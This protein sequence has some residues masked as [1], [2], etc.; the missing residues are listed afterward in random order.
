MTMKTP[1]QTKVELLTSRIALLRTDG[2]NFM[3]YSTG[4]MAQFD[5]EADALERELNTLLEAEAVRYCLTRI[6]SATDWQ[7]LHEALANH[8]T[9]GPWLLEMGDAGLGE[10]QRLIRLAED[11]ADERGIEI[12]Y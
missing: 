3:R 7:D 4:A 12:G 9:V 2:Q 1:H 5:R 6:S 8:P 10:A 11:E